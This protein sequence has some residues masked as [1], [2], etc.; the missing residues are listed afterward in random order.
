MNTFTNL[1]ASIMFFL[2][3]ALSGMWIVSCCKKEEYKDYFKYAVLCT[4]W[5]LGF[6]MLIA[7]KFF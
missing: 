7:I 1:T 5:G 3:V 6:G 2:L 4:V